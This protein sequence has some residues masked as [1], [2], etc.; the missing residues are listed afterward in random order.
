M[1]NGSAATLFGT[2]FVDGVDKSKIMQYLII[3]LLY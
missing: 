2:I 3:D 1:H